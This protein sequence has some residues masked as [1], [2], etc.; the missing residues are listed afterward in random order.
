MILRQCKIAYGK[1][2]EFLNQLF[3]TRHVVYTYLGAEPIK[4]S[5]FLSIGKKIYT[6]FETL[7]D[8]LSFLHSLI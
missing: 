4:M 1:G 2:K 7:P 6:V 5:N 8:L 3:L